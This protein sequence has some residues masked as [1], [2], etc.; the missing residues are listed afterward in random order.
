MISLDRIYDYVLRG[1]RGPTLV[2]FLFFLIFNC[3][4]IYL[5]TILWN[6]FLGKDL[7]VYRLYFSSAFSS[8]VA[9]TSVIHFGGWNFESYRENLKYILLASISIFICQYLISIYILYS[10]IYYHITNN[11]LKNT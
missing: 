3:I 7:G 6:A 11:L 8:W 5:V 4:F 10:F 1:E 9:L 2:N